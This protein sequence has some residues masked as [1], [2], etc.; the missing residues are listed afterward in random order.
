MKSGAQNIIYEGSRIK[1]ANK[2]NDWTSENISTKNEV[3][4]HH[5]NLKWM[6]DNSFI[7]KWK[8]TY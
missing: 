3:G 6:L 7:V 1:N 5:R 8:Y 4:G 2:N